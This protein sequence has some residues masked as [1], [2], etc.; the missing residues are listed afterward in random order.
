MT[1]LPRSRPGRAAV[2]LAAA[3]LAWP[4]FAH[5]GADTATRLAGAQP[6][7]AEDGA[8]GAAVVR[9]AQAAA[10]TPNPDD[11]RAAIE[12]RIGELQL[13][14][15]I[16]GPI[17]VTQR[18]SALEILIPGVRFSGKV[19]IAGV[20]RGA[21]SVGDIEIVAERLANGRYGISVALE[22]TME[23]NDE[24]GVVTGFIV[25]GNQRFEGEW[26]P[27]I[28]NFSRLDA[29]YENIWVTRPGKPPL[30]TVG[31][32]ALNQELEEDAPGT[33]SGP[34]ELRLSDL[35]ISQ[36]DGGGRLTLGGLTVRS[37]AE[38]MRP[39]AQ[40]RFVGEINAVAKRL[41]EAGTNDADP[42]EVLRVLA[43]MPRL[44]A[45]LSTEAEVVDVAFEDG[46]GKRAF[47]LERLVYGFAVSGLAGD[48]SS[49]E[50]SYEHGGLEIAGIE[51]VP[52][53]F[54]PHR[55]ALEIT[56]AG[57]PNE[58]LWRGI[59]DWANASA[60]STPEFAQSVLNDRVSAALLD[61]GSE[62]RIGKLVV[63]TAGFAIEAEG[64][65]RADPESQYSVSGGFEVVVR[66]LDRIVATLSAKPQDG[67]A[68][69]IAGMLALVQALGA[70]EVDESGAAVRRYR[71]EVP[72]DGAILLNGNDMQALFGG[73]APGMRPEPEMQPTPAPN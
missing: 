5:A 11:V 4:A 70:A 14:L 48:R 13:P 52:G 65:L 66:G 68:L 67:D 40:A 60:V 6:G 19:E 63:E 29:L 55:V 27:E 16:G 7:A 72:P 62:L 1:I 23:I 12:E 10:P 37:V 57:L 59:V 3:A 18:D 44:F 28:T 61:A 58:A 8:A 9:V 38:G 45:N 42:M 47:G 71:V 64:A 2:C 43:R 54:V 33:W 41:E 50:V 35:R 56:A 26:A 69:G 34:T 32:V 21:L 36:P 20:K 17:A 24:N 31:A 15:E 49:F 53:E 51:G 39:G 30:V 25:I 22:K 73:F 46:S